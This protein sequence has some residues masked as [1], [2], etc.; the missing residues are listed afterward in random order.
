MA[1]PKLFL[2]GRIWYVWIFGERVSTGCNDRTAALARARELERA[3]V[4]PAYRAAGETTLAEVILAF[5]G[6]RRSK[7]RAAGTMHC[8]GVKVRHLARILGEHTPLSRVTA[9][10][11]DQYIERRLDEEASRNTIN[12]ELVA[13]RGALKLA[14]RRGWY[15]QEPASVLPVAWETGYEPR[16]RALSLGE[17]RALLAVLTADR[18]DGKDSLHHRAAWVALALALGGRRSEVERVRREDVDLAAGL[19]RIR[20]T[21]TEK[22]VRVVPVLSLTRP[23]LELALLWGEPEGRLVR[24]WGSVGRDLPA[25][26]DLAGIGRATPNDLRRTLA[27]WLRASGVE[28]SLVAE[29]LGHVDSRMVERVYGKLTPQQL[30]GALEAR[31]SLGGGVLNLVGTAFDPRDSG[32][33]RD[34]RRPSLPAGF[35]VPRDGIEPPTRGFSVPAILPKKRR[36]TG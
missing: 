21:K 10:A 36:K 3:A 4:D 24:R 9:D 26:C 31:I 16:R 22:A 1:D 2:R 19:V 29:V 34:T 12:K 20:G 13:L 8:Y 25:A 33:A 28:A 15:H 18:L 5:L 11:V 35:S 32:D 27:T 17:A 6:D 14:R 7:G 23:L 30:A